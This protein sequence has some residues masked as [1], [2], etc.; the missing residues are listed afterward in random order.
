ML[1]AAPAN[2]ATSTLYVAIED[3]SGIRVP[4]RV[5][6]QNSKGA[7]L[8]PSDTIAYR[9]MNWNVSEEHFVPQNGTFSLDLP[10]GS[11]TLRI[12]RGKRISPSPR[13]N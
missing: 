1:L 3:E 5:Y 2:R 9:R 8:F 4:A 12:E 13:H 6:L 7:S 10:D 11:Y